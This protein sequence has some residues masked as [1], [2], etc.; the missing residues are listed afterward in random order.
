METPPTI[1]LTLLCGAALALCWIVICLL[2]KFGSQAWNWIDDNEQPIR[3]NPVF[4]W[5]MLRLGYKPA[6]E[7]SPYS[8][9][10]W[11]T[12]DGKKESNG[13]IAFFMPLLILLFCPT[14]IYIGLWLYPVTLAA[15]T[16]FLVGYLARFARR[17][18]KLFDKH[19]KDP[20]AHR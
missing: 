19:L 5:I 10:T 4:S 2:A 18:R 8:A 9:Y 6:R 16:I 1:F 7:V 20:D 14:A 15:I 3:V 17:H 13:E 11:K 12:E